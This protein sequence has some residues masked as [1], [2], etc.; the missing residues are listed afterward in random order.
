MPGIDSHSLKIHSRNAKSHHHGPKLTF[1]SENLIPDNPVNPKP[2][3]HMLKI[4]YTSRIATESRLKI[5][6]IYSKR[7]TTTN[8]KYIS[9]PEPKLRSQSS[10]INFSSPK[11][12][13][14]SLQLT[15]KGLITTAKIPKLTHTHKKSTPRGVKLKNN[16]EI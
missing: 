10:K 9:L 5:Y 4:E 15:L 14:R 8:F 3:S 6:K 13:P 7:P 16:A 12:T 2:D 1:R 11:S